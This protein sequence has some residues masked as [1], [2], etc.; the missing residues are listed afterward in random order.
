MVPTSTTAPPP[1]ATVEDPLPTPPPAATS[2]PLPQPTSTPAAE[3]TPDFTPT[4]AP[5]VTPN[6]TPDATP[7]SAD[8]APDSAAIV[9][10]G[11][12]D[13]GPALVLEVPG[14]AVDQPTTL[15]Y[16]PLTE[17]PAAEIMRGGYAG[18]R[19]VLA[20]T[21]AG[22]AADSLTFLAP[23]GFQVA[24]PQPAEPLDEASIRL[25]YFDAATAAWQPAAC[26]PERVDV[27]NN[28]AIVDVC[29]TGEFALFE[30]VTIDPEAMDEA[31]F[32]PVIRR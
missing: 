12:A 9:N 31:I 1:I 20:A 6:V 24:Y 11:Q 25:H 8:I 32:L 27:A 5:D 26:G 17:Q 22:Q 3:P 15:G 16:M 14:G 7:E 19:F 4:V 13:N 23:V 30:T 2:T 10:F 28:M 18:A 21:Q 29:R